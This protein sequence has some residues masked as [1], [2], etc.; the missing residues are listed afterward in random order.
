MSKRKVETFGMWVP[1]AD[2]EGGW[3]LEYVYTQREQAMLAYR[4]PDGEVGVAEYVDIGG[5]RYTPT[6]ADAFVLSRRITFPSGL[7]EAATSG[8]MLRRVGEFLRRHFVSTPE[9]YAL[10]ARYVLLTWLYDVFDVVPYLRF[11]GGSE[12]DREGVA[13]L[14]G[15]VC[16]RALDVGDDPATLKQALAAHHGTAL[17]R[18]MDVSEKFD[19]RLGILQVG[20]LR[21]MAQVWHIERAPGGGFKGRVVDVFGPKVVTM[22]GTFRDPAL[23][24]RC[25]TLTLGADALLDGSYLREAEALRNMLLRWR[26]EHWRADMSLSR[27]GVRETWGRFTKWLCEVVV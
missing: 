19:G 11:R 8:E 13:A 3:L 10:V 14:V 5:V 23:E 20:A 16:Y 25:L 26:L 21:R 22:A 9:G 6:K 18:R 24:G 27:G 15:S 17:M 1:S 4:S 12:A 7:G 2:S